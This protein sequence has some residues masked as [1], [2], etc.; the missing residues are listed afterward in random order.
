[1]CG[2]PVSMTSRQRR[3][4]RLSGELLVGQR[5]PPLLRR[6]RGPESLRGPSNGSLPMARRW[7]HRPVLLTMTTTHRR[8]PTWATCCT[9]T[10]TG[11]S[12]SPS[13]G[14]GARLLPRARAERCTAALLLEV[15][16]IGAGPRAA[17]GRAP[18][19]FASAQYVNDRPYAARQH[20][21][22]SPSTDV[23]AHRD[24]RRCA[25]RPELAA[26]PIPLEIRGARPCPAG[27]GPTCCA[28]CSNRWAGR[29]AAD[30]G[31]L[32]TDVPGL[33]RLAGTCDA[34]PVRRAAAGRRAA[35]AVR[36]AAGAGRR[37]ALLGRPRRGGQADPGRRGLAGR[38]PG[39][40]S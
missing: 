2:S 10:P 39:A 6:V 25:A 27:A 12:R 5:V 24:D 14:H 18:D 29:S 28:G 7:D 26:T 22:A 15:D 1:M 4:S 36:A 8:P 31:A 9:S 11:R 19:G 17:K 21:R 40:A 38:A 34:A 3:T 30:A 35:P 37:Q 16:P 23:F 13:Y 33:G 20:A 32:D